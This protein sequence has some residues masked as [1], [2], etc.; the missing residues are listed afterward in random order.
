M[1]KLLLSV[2]VFLFVAITAIAQER[3]VTGTVTS[4]EDNKP[5]PGAS[6]KVRGTKTG[7]STGAD[8]KWIRF[9]SCGFEI[10]I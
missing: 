9:K 10:K 5:L 1:K 8:G 2:F 7:V 6:V 3:V 4:A